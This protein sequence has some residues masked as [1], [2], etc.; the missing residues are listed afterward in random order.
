MIPYTR[1]TL[2]KLTSMYPKLKRIFASGMITDFTYAR[3][4]EK[5]CA[6]FFGVKHVIAVS[7]ATSAIM[8]VLKCLDIKGE[9]I[10]PS[11]TF[12]AGGH[13]LLWCG[14]KPVFVDID[15][16][17]FNMDSSAIEK[18]ITKKTGAIFP[19]H[20]FG[21]PCDIEKIQKIAKEH[22]LKV[23]YD[24]A[25]AFG[26]NYKGKSVACFGDATIFSLTPTK[27]LTV[28]EG[29]LIVTNSDALAK[30]LRLA[31]NYGD[32]FNR[33]EEFLGL[34]SR[35]GEMNAILGLEGLK[36]FKKS[37]KKRVSLAN[38]YKKELAGVK[39]LS[40]QKTSSVANSVVKD[41]AVIIDE[42]QFGLS[43]DALF[44]VLAAKGVHA[45]IYFDPPLHKKN[46]Y[47]I[48]KNALLPQTVLVHQNII[49]LPLWS[50]MSE[51]TVRKVCNV[52]RSHKEII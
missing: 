20:V 52:I 41:L 32:S 1:P 25:H 18:K 26:S 21:N 27:V 22:N 45:K 4:F 37:I 13:A 14:L 15:P 8:L 33:K 7:S 9:V 46:V 10:V 40:F 12:S 2:P 5:K 3:E 39:G 51:D 11:F 31:R 19:T 6:D 49:N 38:L 30:K 28:G 36:I 24:G 34:S 44:A 50:H 29:G 42:K 43:R 35:M 48:Y 17:T 47:R 16:N 23:L